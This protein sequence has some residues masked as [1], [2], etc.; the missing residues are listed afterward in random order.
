MGIYGMYI[1]PKDEFPHAT[2]RQGVVVAVYPGATSEEVEQETTEDTIVEAIEQAA[3]VIADAI[4]EDAP[5]DT[6]DKQLNEAKKILQ[7]KING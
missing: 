1:M 2:I 5:E 4:T 7:G 6:E 3:E